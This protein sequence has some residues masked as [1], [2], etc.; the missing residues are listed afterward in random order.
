MSARAR[1]SVGGLP[2]RQHL[3]YDSGPEDWSDAPVEVVP[4]KALPRNCTSLGPIQLGGWVLCPA[5]P[6]AKGRPSS[7]REPGARYGKP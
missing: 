3:S 1:G 7:K 6:V 2:H 5:Y 4:S